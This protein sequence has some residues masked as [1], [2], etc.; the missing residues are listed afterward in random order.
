M[1]DGM[2][3][4]A[5]NSM[6]AHKYSG[7]SSHARTTLLV[8]ISLLAWVLEVLLLAMMW[9][10]RT[11]PGVPASFYLLPI[12]HLLPWLAALQCLQKVRHAVRNGPLD[13]AGADICYS[14]IIALL[15]T[16]YVALSACE[17]A[18]GLAWRFGTKVFW[19]G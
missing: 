3:A 13:A 4:G 17:I 19:F 15:S 6:Q 11:S 18:F 2:I 14:V 10:A 16:A 8:L 12:V 7:G 1:V 5:G 9:S